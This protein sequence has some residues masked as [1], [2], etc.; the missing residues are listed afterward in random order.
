MSRSIFFL[1]LLSLL[2]AIPGPA[3][4]HWFIR[5]EGNLSLIRKTS[6]TTSYNTTIDNEPVR[7][8]VAARS[9]FDR[10]LGA[11]LSGGFV[12]PTA[13][14]RLSL[15][16]AA[17]LV[18][19]SYRAH[20][21]LDFRSSGDIYDL[22]MPGFRAISVQFDG[23]AGGFSDRLFSSGKPYIISPENTEKNFKQGTVRH[24]YA[25]LQ[26]GAKYKLLRKTAIGLGVVPY[27]LVQSTTHTYKEELTPPPIQGTLL[28][29]TK[30]QAKDDYHTAGMA[31]QAK[32]EQALNARFSLQALFTHHFSKIYKEQPGDVPGR[33][34]K[35]Q[36]A[37]LGMS[38]YFN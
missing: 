2:F 5:P 18:M 32:V 12:V 8:T 31:A 21:A 17:G 19:T 38:Y 27:L 33:K 35:M 13:V 30:S 6:N 37:A 28:R 26:I 4:V 34:P 11:G 29:Q 25:Q 1:L 14:K 10:Q 23:Y 9:E 3:Q 15:E 20:T 16:A 7:A 36:Y 22:N 24:L